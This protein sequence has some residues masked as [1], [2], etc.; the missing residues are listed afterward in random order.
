V[1]HLPPDLQESP[2]THLESSMRE[3][4]EEE[5]SRCDTV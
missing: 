5:R 3:G 4:K 2:T 1:T